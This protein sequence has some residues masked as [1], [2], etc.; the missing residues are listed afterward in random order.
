MHLPTTLDKVAVSRLP[1]TASE[2]QVRLECAKY[3]APRLRFEVER[4]LE[5]AQ[6]SS[7]A[8]LMI[9]LDCR[10]ILFCFSYT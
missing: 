2:A 4:G 6:S 7:T 9:F 3:G 5:A 8:P 1:K 10:H